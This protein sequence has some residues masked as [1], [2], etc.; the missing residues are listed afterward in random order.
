MYKKLIYLV[1]F[2]F[3]LSLVL[4]N[5]VEADLVGYGSLMRVPA[6]WILQVMASIYCCL[7]LLRGK[8]GYSGVRYTFTVWAK[9]T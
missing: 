1:S 6:L 7:I 4:P 8:M 3:V 5:A 2:V 9:E